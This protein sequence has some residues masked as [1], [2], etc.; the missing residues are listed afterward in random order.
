MSRRQFLAGAGALGGVAALT[1]A[2]SALAQ[3]TRKASIAQPE[4]TA[5]MPPMAPTAPLPPPA[6]AGFDHVVVLA[7]E[8][9]SFDHMLGWLPGAE[10]RQG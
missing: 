3:M 4:A 2:A 6:Q 10:G 8:N 7:M 9:R 1:P 5:P